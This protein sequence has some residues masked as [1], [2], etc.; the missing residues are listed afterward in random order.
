MELRHL[1]YFI[2]VAEELHFRRAA[3]RLNISQPPLSQQIKLLE[4]ELGAALFERTNKKVELTQ[5][6]RLFLPEARATIERA[7]RAADVVR[8]SLHGELGELRIG[9]F[10]SA[11][12]VPEISKAIRVYRE[13]YKG[14]SLVLNELESQQQTLVLV[15]EGEDI[16]I[17]RSVAAPVLPRTILSR[18]VVEEPLVVVMRSDH[19]L[20]RRSDPVSM[21]DLVDEPF[22]FYGEKMGTVLP[23]IVYDLCHDAGF[24]PRIGQLANANTTMIGLV[25]AGLGIAVVPNALA[26]LAHADIAVHPLKQKTATVSAWVLWNA[27]RRSLLVDA[28]LKLI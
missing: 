24:E 14:V 5:A 13:Q 19:P 16:A 15:N 17:V 18:R 8:K 25:A 9:L 3:E 4:L 22:V 23:R 1:R 11:P 12:L 7:G 10:P 20:N 6:G 21:S 27:R 2:A 26:R 28:F